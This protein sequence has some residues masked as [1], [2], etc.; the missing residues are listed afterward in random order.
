MQSNITN[1]IAVVTI[2][3]CLENENHLK[4]YVSKTQDKQHLIYHIE[5]G[6]N[7]SFDKRRIGSASNETVPEDY[8]RTKMKMKKF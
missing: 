3:F 6:S 5:V 7:S 8:S 1:N 4:P 2:C